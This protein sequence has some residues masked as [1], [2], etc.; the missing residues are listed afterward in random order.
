[1][2]DRQRTRTLILRIITAA[3]VRPPWGAAATAADQITTYTRRL[4]HE[5]WLEG[6][7]AHR[8]EQ[9]AISPYGGGRHR[10][11]RNV[12]TVLREAKADAQRRP[13][14]FVFEPPPFNG[15]TVPTLPT[16]FARNMDCLRNHDHALH[17]RNMAAEQVTQDYYPDWTRR[18]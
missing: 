3:L 4:Q 1:M 10:A 2:T 8:L 5:A 6:Y 9:D 17:N 12:L 16:V 11:E 15:P 7:K 18:P 13:N 14:P